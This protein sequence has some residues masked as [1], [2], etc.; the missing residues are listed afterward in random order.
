MDDILNFY[1]ITER[2]GT[3][4]QPT[5]AQFAQIAAAGYTA[6][7][8][9]AMPDSDN[10]IAQEGAL[11]SSQGMDYIHLPV[12]FDA[13]G[14]RHLRR[15]FGVMTA[16]G[17]DKVFVHCALNMRVSVFMFKYLT[18]IEGVDEV[19]ATSPLLGQWLPQMDPVWR[20]II[21]LERDAIGG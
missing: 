10:A 4:G 9:L 3:A 17:D 12:P 20:R 18:L 6:V 2:V 16:L 11:V 7:I 19:Q 21:E 5:P 14:E 13:P 15:F 1:P 8:N